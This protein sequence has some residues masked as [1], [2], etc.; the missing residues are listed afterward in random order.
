M[1]EKQLADLTK[2]IYTTAK[3]VANRNR[4]FSPCKK[5]AVV[6]SEGCVYVVGPVEF[7]SNKPLLDWSL[8]AVSEVIAKAII[9]GDV[10]AAKK[11]LEGAPRVALKPVKIKKKVKNEK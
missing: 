8:L 3:N 9:T 1:F 10:A 11:E 6:D 5:W 2:E 7:G 4:W